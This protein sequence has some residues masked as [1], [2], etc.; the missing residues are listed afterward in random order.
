MDVQDERHCCRMCIS[1][2]SLQGLELRNTGSDRVHSEVKH[3]S[4]IKEYLKNC[5]NIKRRFLLYS[6]TIER[7]ASCAPK[8]SN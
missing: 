3:L 5:T 2:L 8:Y 4:V 7:V 1:T 6:L